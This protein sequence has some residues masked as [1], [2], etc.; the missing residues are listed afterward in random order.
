VFKAVCGEQQGFDHGGEAFFAVEA[1]FADE[2]AD[3][4]AAGFCRVEGD[5]AFH[6]FFREQFGLCGF[7]AAVEAFDADESA[8]FAQFFSPCAGL[9]LHIIGRLINITYKRGGDKGA[10]GV[11]G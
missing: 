6:E 11:L 8:F 10:E 9:A 3:V 5:V 4:A 1:T 2:G 7:S